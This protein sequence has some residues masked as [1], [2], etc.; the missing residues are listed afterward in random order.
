VTDVSRALRGTLPL[1]MALTIATA[2]MLPASA[3]AAPPARTAA[4]TAPGSGLTETASHGYVSIATS[5]MA[6]KN[7]ATRPAGPGTV[8]GSV[9]RDGVIAVCVLIVALICVLLGGA[10]RRRR[11]AAQPAAPMRARHGGGAG[12]G[13]GRGASRGSHARCARAAV[14]NGTAQA[15]PAAWTAAGTAA[16][17][18]SSAAVPGR[19]RIVPLAN[20]RALGPHSRTQRKK[21]EDKPPWEPARPPGQAT[22]AD[23]APSADSAPAS[24]AMPGRVPLAPPPASAAKGRGVTEL[25][26]WEQ[27]ADGYAAAPVPDD[28]PDWAVPSSGPMYVWNPAANAGPFPAA[29]EPGSPPPAEPGASPSPP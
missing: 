4:F 1:I 28:L 18:G 25:P 22:A 26:P 12:H 24:S 3:L 21:T 17:P 23:S 2:F 14:E 15:R 9:L 5:D 11:R 7:V 20:P 8:A 27:P 10:T 6:A 29:A 19:P 16:R 13:H